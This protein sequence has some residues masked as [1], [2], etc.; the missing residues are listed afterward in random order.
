MGASYRGR[1]QRRVKFLHWALLAPVYFI[2]IANYNTVTRWL[3]ARIVEPEETATAGQWL[4]KHI[5]AT[6]EEQLEA[7]FSARS[8]Q[9]LYESQWTV[10]HDSVVTAD[11]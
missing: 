3:T 8:V 6:T 2:I 9:R 11:D 5:P 7:V 4:S 10:S 1:Q